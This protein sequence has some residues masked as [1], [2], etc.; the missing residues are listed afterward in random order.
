VLLVPGGGD[1]PSN[2]DVQVTHIDD[3]V[4]KFTHKALPR[5]STPVAV[6]LSCLANVGR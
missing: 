5:H 4:L 6:D 1:A 3:V 2:A